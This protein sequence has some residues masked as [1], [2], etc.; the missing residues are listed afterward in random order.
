MMIDVAYETEISIDK[1]L[2]NFDVRVVAG[3]ADEKRVELFAGLYKDKKLKDLIMVTPPDKD[4]FY[5]LVDGRTRLAAQ[6]TNKAKKIKVR[7]L[8]PATEQDYV[9]FAYIRNTE[10]SK[11]PELE[12][13]KKT[14]EQLLRKGVTPKEIMNGSFS[15]HESSYRLKLACDQVRSNL[16]KQQ[17]AMAKRAYFESS[18]AD[19]KERCK[20]IAR[21]FNISEGALRK[22]C[23][24]YDVV[25]NKRN[26]F[27]NAV[28]KDLG[29]T[30]NKRKTWVKNWVKRNEERYEAGTPTGQVLE[31]FDHLI[32]Q[33]K[34]DLQI[35]ELAKSRF[36]KRVNGLG[37]FIL[38][39]AQSSSSPSIQ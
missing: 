4:G 2:D 6:K 22:A 7:V 10:G 24:G 18:I 16:M 30:A 36:E 1:I 13:L 25:T 3:S 21:Q 9:M 27:L 34:S 17:V 23:I 39:Q 29:I 8:K 35:L 11:P 20:I 19:P 32:K 28:K 5:T 14:V 38:Q 26:T 31:V 33:Q 37:D 15:D 12:D